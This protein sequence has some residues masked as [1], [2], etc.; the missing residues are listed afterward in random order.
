MVWIR[1]SGGGGGGRSLFSQR[2]RCSAFSPTS[3]RLKCLFVSFFPSL[4]SLQ[5]TSLFAA[6]AFSFFSVVVVAVG[7]FLFFPPTPPQKKNGKKTSHCN[8]LHD[9]AQTSAQSS[10]EMRRVFHPIM[11]SEPGAYVRTPGD[12]ASRVLPSHFSNIPPPPTLSSA[13]PT[14]LMPGFSVPL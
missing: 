8:C 12:G 2:E 14:L 7:L 9:G 13:L 5:G 3:S 11:K 10:G 4:P 1:R 6:H